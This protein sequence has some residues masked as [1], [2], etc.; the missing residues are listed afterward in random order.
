[1][2][3]GLG[4]FDVFKASCLERWWSCFMTSALRFL[5]SGAAVALFVSSETYHDTKR[6]GKVWSRGGMGPVVEV[7]R[8]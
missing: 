6:I 2:P 1:M 4:V 3:L 5:G 7:G 8:R